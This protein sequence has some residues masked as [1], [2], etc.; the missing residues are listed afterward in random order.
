MSTHSDLEKRYSK[1]ASNDYE[2]ILSPEEY[3]SEAHIYSNLER[4][5]AFYDDTIISEYSEIVNTSSTT[6]I[7]EEEIYSDPGHSLADIYACFETKKIHMIQT[8]DVR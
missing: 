8:S 7:D 6:A 1:I 3:M 2:A 5:S 4:E